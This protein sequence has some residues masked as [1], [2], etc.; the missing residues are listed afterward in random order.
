MQDELRLESLS[1]P[2]GNSEGG[3]ESGWRNNVEIDS[4]CATQ[5][6]RDGDG[7]EDEFR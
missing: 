3:D 6:Q 4:S 2:D 7:E 1:Q 5:V